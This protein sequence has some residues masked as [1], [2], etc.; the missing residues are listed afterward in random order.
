MVQNVTQ[1]LFFYFIHTCK[2]FDFKA[3]FV[4]N[5]SLQR[6]TNG[7]D[8]RVSMMWLLARLQL[9]SCLWPKRLE[10]GCP[11]NSHHHGHKLLNFTYFNPVNICINQSTKPPL[12]GSSSSTKLNEEYQ[13]LDK[14]SH[15]L[16]EME[17]TLSQLL[18]NSKV[19]EKPG[20]WTKM[21]KRVNKYF[22]ITYITVIFVFLIVIFLKW[23]NVLWWSTVHDVNMI[24]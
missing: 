6:W 14:L 23:Q 16:R 13:T 24:Y 20:Y 5:I 11:L 3:V 1:H 7:L 19:E 2:F 18:I 9:N 8:V 15:E 4:S 10:L 17:K 22:F 21:A 12:Q